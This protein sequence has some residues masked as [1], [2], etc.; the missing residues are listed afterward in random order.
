MDSPTNYLKEAIQSFRVRNK[1]CHNQIFYTKEGHKL[2]IGD[3]E[4][5]YLHDGKAKNI[6]APANNDLVCDL[7][8]GKIEIDPKK[9]LIFIPEECDLYCY[10]NSCNTLSICTSFSYDD[11]EDLCR[12]YA[13]NCFP[14]KSFDFDV[15]DFKKDLRQ[16]IQ[17]KFRPYLFE[18]KRA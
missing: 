15:K 13:G 7:L 4:Y 2:H 17:E 11:V 5:F 9:N 12:L 3:N 18:T 16:K 10:F 6:I 1:L 8:A 14:S